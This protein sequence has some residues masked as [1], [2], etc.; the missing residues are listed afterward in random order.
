MPTTWALSFLGLGLSIYLTIAHYAGSS[1]LA[2]STSGVVN[3]SVVITSPESYVFGIPVAV[4]G[5]VAFVGLII[6]NS[7]WGWKYPK[8]WLHQF[9][10]Y[11]LVASML[12]VLYL[13]YCELV[14]LN[15]ICEYCTMVHVVTL[16]LLIIL[17]RVTPAQLG[18]GE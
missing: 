17:T 10:F 11:S 13:V 1:I 4:L 8:R 3:C 5:L 12:F 16:S 18:W 2:C 15:H 7:P 9:R 6:I 14:K